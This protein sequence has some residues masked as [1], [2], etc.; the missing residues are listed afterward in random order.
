M[1]LQMFRVC[2]LFSN[3]GNCDVLNRGS[4]HHLPALF[5]HLT[6][7]TSVDFSC[8]Y[9]CLFFLTFLPASV[10]LIQIQ[11]L[12]GGRRSFPTCCGLL[13]WP[14]P[15]LCETNRQT[16]AQPP[17]GSSLDAVQHNVENQLRMLTS[18]T[19]IWP[20][21]S[22]QVYCFRPPP[23]NQIKL[24]RIFQ[25]WVNERATGLGQI[26]LMAAFPLIYSCVYS[27]LLSWPSPSVKPR[28]SCLVTSGV[29]CARHNLRLHLWTRNRRRFHTSSV[30]LSLTERVAKLPQ[31]QRVD[32]FIIVLAITWFQRQLDVLLL[33]NN[34]LLFISDRPDRLTR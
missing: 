14:L 23:L 15:R 7:E 33:S 20:P 21:A 5:L 24:P 18:A 26:V 1:K 29:I 13:I 25:L 30:I 8:I 4:I 17:R 11:H 10:P 3:S 2:S 6:A 12:G 19:F 27:S 9:F 28:K 31:D 16:R 32:M 34:L 22:N